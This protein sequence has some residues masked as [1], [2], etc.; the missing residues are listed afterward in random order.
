MVVVLGASV[1]VVDRPVD[2]VELDPVA[3]GIVLSD[4]PSPSEQPMSAA[5]DSTAVITAPRYIPCRP[6]TARLLP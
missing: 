5:A 6:T 3:G 4:V 1:V 2:S